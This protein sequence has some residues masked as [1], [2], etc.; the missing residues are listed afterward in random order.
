MLKYFVETT[1]ALLIAGI[2]IGMM[3][4][5]ARSAYGKKGRLPADIGVWLGV[6][7]AVVMAYL[8]NATRLIDT[9]LWNMR[10]FIAAGVILILFWV[11][12]ALRR[13]MKRAGD[14]LPPAV[15]D[16]CGGRT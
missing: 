14:V 9:S 5:Y 3:T 10:N 13:P 16:L 4:G 12:S 15:L 1:E 8:K 6:I 11:L 7:G 2:L